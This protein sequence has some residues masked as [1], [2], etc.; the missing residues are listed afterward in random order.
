[1]MVDS[2]HAGYKATRRSCSGFMVFVN[3]VLV[4]WHSKK[5]SMIKS[6]VLGAECVALKARMEC[7]RGL[8]YK[9]RMIGVPPTEPIFTYG[10]NMSVIHNTQRPESQL[11]KKSNS[12]CYHTIR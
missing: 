1:M 9:L 12:V 10:D 6:S 11:K 3:N 5:H 7:V 4:N 8:C 2:D